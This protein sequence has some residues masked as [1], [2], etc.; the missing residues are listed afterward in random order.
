M[1]IGSLVWAVPVSKS[2]TEPYVEYNNILWTSVPWYPE[3]VRNQIKSIVYLSPRWNQ[4]IAPNCFSHG[5]LERLY[6][7]WYSAIFSCNHA[8][9]ILLYIYYNCCI[10]QCDWDTDLVEGVQIYGFEILFEL[11]RFW[12]SNQQI[13]KFQ[14]TFDDQL[15]AR[16]V[17]PI[18]RPGDAGVQPVIRRGEVGDGQQLTTLLP[19]LPHR[20]LP[21]DCSVVLLPGDRREGMVGGSHVNE[22]SQGDGRP[23]TS[24]LVTRPVADYAVTLTCNDYYDEGK[25][26]V[27]VFDTPQVVDC[28]KVESD[29]ALLPMVDVTGNVIMI[30]KSV[31]GRFWTEDLPIFSPDA[32]TSVPS[33]Q[34]LPRGQI[35]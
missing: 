23:S 2:N 34:A 27:Q 17:H 9:N 13:L 14:P 1:T 24:S 6:Y 31:L 3:L 15:G 16:S 35:T 11:Y 4:S 21:F 26:K 7:G 5:S 20:I 25:S 33:R 30:E 28:F 29:A 10:I 12:N 18:G 32:L 19:G 22:A 8:F